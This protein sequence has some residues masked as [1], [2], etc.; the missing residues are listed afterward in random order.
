MTD[1]SS[2]RDPND[3]ELVTELLRGPRRG[4]PLTQAVKLALLVLVLCFVG[5]ALWKQFK[6]IDFSTLS[7]SFLPLLASF[8]FLF[9]VSSVQMI[10]Y[11]SLLSAYAHAPRWREMA[12]V[13]WVPPL[14][15]YVPGKVAAL[16][17]AMYML[18]KFKIPGSVAV[19]VVLALD[20]LAVLAGLI[21]GAPL[22]LW[23]PVREAWPW[24]WVVCVLI[25]IAGCTMLH[26][27]IFG[28]LINFAL[29]KLKKQ[30]L[31]KM[32][33]IGTYLIP[34]ACAF[35]Q[36]VFAGLSLWFMARSVT[37]VSIDRI[38][39]FMSLAAL[40][41]TVGYLALFAPGGLGVQDGISLL[42]LK[43]ILGPISAIP[44]TLFRIART[45]VEVILAGVG[46]LVLRTLNE[47]KREEPR[48]HTNAHE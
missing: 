8:L 29:R 15:K 48:M 27:A 23:Q 28:R 47:A 42:V 24:A 18:K 25:A 44:V 41:Q 36:W 9:A 40:G 31:P 34:V 3:P 16:L 1:E 20:G 32:P 19:S 21:C 22:L 39:L 17:G 6:L 38:P 45:L 5:W 12:A 14:G 13:A 37:N 7:F 35:A 46:M 33:P 4:F 43:N 2:R 11:R 26:P 10:S 30:P